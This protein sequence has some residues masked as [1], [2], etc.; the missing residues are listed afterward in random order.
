MCISKNLFKIF[1]LINILSVFFV[2]SY[3]NFERSDPYLTDKYY[4][5]WLSGLGE[6]S[7]F[8]LATLSQVIYIAADTIKAPEPIANFLVLVTVQLLNISPEKILFLYSVLTL[9]LIVFSISLKKKEI[10]GQLLLLFLIA[11]ISYY[12]FVLFN[13]THRL[14]LA[15]LLLIISFI[16]AKKGKDTAASLLFV[17]SVFTHF[18][19]FLVAP[20]IYILNREKYVTPI[21]SAYRVT[22]QMVVCMLGVFGAIALFINDSQNLD[23]LMNLIRNKTYFLFDLIQYIFIPLCVLLLVFLK[24]YESSILYRYRV[25]W[26]IAFYCFVLYYF[27]TSRVLM[28]LYVASV[29]IVY[30]NPILLRMRKDMRVHY[31]TPCLLVLMFY[32]I[33]KY[34][35]FNVL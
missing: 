13:I 11:G 21:S 33:Y 30:F 35:S 9:I 15:V 18:S 29:L 31:I 19:I 23:P 28:L 5:A 16:F 34:I 32:D 6:I 14:K 24:K 1:V 17:F 8:G 26:A 7:N 20:I 10:M 25:L 12:W 27:G 4:H 22:L 2:S 3:L